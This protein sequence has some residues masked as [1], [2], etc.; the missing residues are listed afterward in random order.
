LTTLAATYGAALTLRRND[1]DAVRRA[2]D[3]SAGS[4]IAAPRG[5]DA[6]AAIV[7]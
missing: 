1:I 6:T 7:G 4:P 2:R 3:T 5:V